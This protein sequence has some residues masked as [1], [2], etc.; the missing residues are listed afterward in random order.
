MVNFAVKKLVL[1]VGIKVIW[2]TNSI[3]IFVKSQ[4]ENTNSKGYFDSKP[5]LKQEVFKISGKQK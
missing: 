4:L 3:I 2:Y 5:V 1:N